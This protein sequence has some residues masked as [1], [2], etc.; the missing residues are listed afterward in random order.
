MLVV[1][2]VMVVLYNN[3]VWWDWPTTKK[4]KTNRR[5]RNQIILSNR[6]LNISF[7]NWLYNCNYKPNQ[8]I[9]G[10]LT[11]TVWY[12]STPNKD[13]VWNK[14][15]NEMN[16]NRTLVTLMCK[17]RMLKKDRKKGKKYFQGTEKPFC[18]E[19]LHRIRCVFHAHCD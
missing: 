7:N 10:T 12:I 5:N 14:C 11:G 4:K 1:V 15:L 8:N 3:I 9:I 13:S 19:I 17:L 18:I 2:M 6:D 16:V